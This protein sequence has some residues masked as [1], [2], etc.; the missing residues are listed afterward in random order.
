[1]SRQLKP[2]APRGGR[3]WTGGDVMRLTAMAAK[4]IPLDRIARKL[5][6]TEAAVR[7][8]AAKHRI[9]L[10]PPA[11]RPTGPTDKRPYGG[12]TVRREPPEG[13]LF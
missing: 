5:G 13:R 9:Q 3:P 11:K 7:T 8:E 2:N 12:R 4:E 6:R 10:A 1:M